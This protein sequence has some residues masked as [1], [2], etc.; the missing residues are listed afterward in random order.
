MTTDHLKDTYVMEYL[1]MKNEK[2][3]PDRNRL[4]THASRAVFIKFTYKKL[5]LS[6]TERLIQHP[7]TT[8]RSGEKD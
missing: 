7:C 8:S 1:N 2:D 4:K 3:K 6:Q 5:K